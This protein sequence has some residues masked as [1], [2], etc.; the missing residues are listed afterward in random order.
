[1]HQD[2]TGLRFT[3]NSQ[4]S[5]LFNSRP[6]ALSH[7]SLFSPWL[8]SIITPRSMECKTLQRL[9]K[10]FYNWASWIG[11]MPLWSVQTELYWEC[12]QLQRLTFRLCCAAVRWCHWSLLHSLTATPKQEICI[13]STNK[14]ILI[15]YL[16]SLKAIFLMLHFFCCK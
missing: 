3:E 11:K 14:Q 10:I 8:L 2:I 16:I 13:N 6:S 4:R 1:M 12:S 7:F 15:L 5:L 9:F